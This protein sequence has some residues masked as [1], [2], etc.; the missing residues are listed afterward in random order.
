MIGAE[1][2]GRMR[3]EYVGRIWIV[4]FVLVNGDPGGEQFAGVENAA[5][6]QRVTKTGC[7]CLRRRGV[8]SERI[9]GQHAL[10]I[11]TESRL[12]GRGEFLRARGVAAEGDE[13]GTLVAI[14]PIDD[15]HPV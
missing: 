10:R 4:E 8:V 2:K 5:A 1:R 13:Q 7:R 12:H 6:E 15:W 3:Q 9:C 11:A 14:R